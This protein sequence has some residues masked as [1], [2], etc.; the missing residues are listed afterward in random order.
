MEYIR[1]TPFTT[2]EADK[3][4]GEYPEDV[5]YRSDK[6][7]L[8][9]IRAIYGLACERNKW[10][11]FL[12][13]NEC[14]TADEARKKSV[15]L[16]MDNIN[17]VPEESGAVQ[18]TGMFDDEEVDKISEDILKL[19]GYEEIIKVQKYFQAQLKLRC[20]TNK[21]KKRSIVVYNGMVITT[22]L[23]RFL[24]SA[25]LSFTPWITPTPEMIELETSLTQGKAEY[26]ACLEK[27]AKKLDLRSLYIEDM[28]GEFESKMLNARVRNIENDN[29]QIRRKIESYN[30]AIRDYQ[31]M[32]YE[33]NI[34][35]I[36]MKSKSVEDANDNAIA[37]YF[38]ANKALYVCNSDVS[39]D[40]EFEF[41]V[42]T[43]LEYYDPDQVE[44]AL[45]NK[46]SFIYRSD[47]GTYDSDYISTKGMAKLMR[48]IF[49]DEKLKLHVCGAY[50]IDIESGVFAPRGHDFSTSDAGMRCLPNPHL[51][52]YSCL[53]NYERQINECVSNG[54]Y[55]MAV[56][57]CIASCKSLNFG[58]YVVMSRFMNMMYG[59]NY[60]ANR[61]CIEL[62]TGEI[63]T[64]ED[65]L[66]YLENT[67]KEESSN[68]TENQD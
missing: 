19:D 65:A 39:G 66:V 30:S 13:L 68:G 63:V 4:F 27:L 36:G 29:D 48:A 40:S 28:L 41:I 59:H 3:Y 49:C 24:Q 57:Q 12:R 62:P 16:L 58:D 47:Y 60:D 11:L 8:S 23:D 32:I 43:T 45:E 37:D 9:T 17:G 6:S 31:G 5:N 64:P 21:E 33:N 51:Y 44:H 10:T 55:V 50:V 25:L 67:E 1:Q 42:D 54:D 52:Y 34:K 7:F 2:V 20:F 22:A 56:Q 53:G 15:T 61:K 26:L 18:L 38:K 46:R 14:Y 35:I